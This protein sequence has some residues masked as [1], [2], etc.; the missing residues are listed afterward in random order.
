[1]ND[2]DKDEFLHNLYY[3][4]HRMLGRDSMFEYVSKTL[5][6]TDTF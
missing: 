3:T 4:Q 1:M 2:K 5:K 6:N